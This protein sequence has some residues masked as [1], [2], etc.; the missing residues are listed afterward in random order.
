MSLVVV[1]LL[2]LKG[3]D[4]DIISGKY[5]SLLLPM[6]VAAP[7]YRFWVGMQVDLLYLSIYDYDFTTAW[8]CLCVHAHLRECAPVYVGL[9]YV[10]CFI[11]FEL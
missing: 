5:R 10:S 11:H 3:F 7:T 9:V 1:I 4:L 6:D 2:S 8:V